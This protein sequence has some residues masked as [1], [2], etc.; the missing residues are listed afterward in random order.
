MGGHWRG[1]RK[2]GQCGRGQR[3]RGAGVA[4]RTWV[5]ARRVAPACPAA[6]GR[7]GRPRATLR[8]RDG[9]VAGSLVA[10]AAA[11]AVHGLGVVLAVLAERLVRR[12]VVLAAVE[13]EV[14][15]RVE[16]QSWTAD[17][18]H[19]SHIIDFNRFSDPDGIKTFRLINNQNFAF[20][21]GYHQ[22]HIKGRSGQL[23]MVWLNHPLYE[24][25][26][27][28]IYLIWDLLS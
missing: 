9:A 22:E 5:V 6:D 13:L 25:Y 11:A 8:T 21:Y 14:D 15:V 27:S 20:G 17:K 16:L 1:H 24:I 7:A 19:H 2:R 12:H 18:N 4:Q 10:V 26:L 23:P 28:Q 3:R